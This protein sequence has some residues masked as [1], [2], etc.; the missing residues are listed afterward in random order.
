MFIIYVIIILG[1]IWL[2]FMKMVC[3]DQVILCQYYLF[4]SYLDNPDEG[5]YP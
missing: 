5:A 3:H 2:V 4:L 1:S